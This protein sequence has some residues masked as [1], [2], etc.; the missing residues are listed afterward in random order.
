VVCEDTNQ[1]GIFKSQIILLN[2]IM[3][4]LFQL[5]ML[6]LMITIGGCCTKM[7]CECLPDPVVS[8]LF[9][10]DATDSQSFPAGSES[11]F[12]I[13]RTSST[14]SVID[15]LIIILD[16]AYKT[17]NNYSYRFS[18]QTFGYS[19]LKG[20]NFIIVNRNIGFADTLSDL[21]YNKEKRKIRCNKCI[22]GYDYTNCETIET[23]QFKNKNSTITQQPLLINK[24]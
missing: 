2:S 10:Y 18:E 6:P 19:T 12:Y 15:S 14:Y 1:V 8:L 11:G 7:D 13:I 21:T 24:N 3:N 5:I 4:K 22:I 17:G 20:S 9:N 16:S 23:V